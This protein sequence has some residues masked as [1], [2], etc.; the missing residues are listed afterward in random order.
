MTRFR[1]RCS[2]IAGFFAI[3]LFCAAIGPVSAQRVPTFGSRIRFSTDSLE[4]GRW[5]TGKHLALDDAVLR[6]ITTTGDTLRV[7]RPAIY[8]FEMSEG[9]RS[10][11][12]AGVLA[13]AVAGASAGLFLRAIGCSG[14]TVQDPSYHLLREMSCEDDGPLKAM[15][16]GLLIGVPLGGIIGRLAR[17]DLWV[18][19]TVERFP[20]SP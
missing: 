3:T 9:R 4:S 18:P 16:V 12:R 20:R 19:V 2:A 17:S 11:T 15:G 10:H 6:M 8:H 7:P 14:K 13:G 5:T 1:S